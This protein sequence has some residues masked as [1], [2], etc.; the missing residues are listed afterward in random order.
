M[1]S[2]PKEKSMPEE[3][4][5]SPPPC[6]RRRTWAKKRT[7]FT[8]VTYERL[9]ARQKEQFNFQKIAAT[10][11]DYGFSCIK[12]A[13]DWQ[14]ADFLA[15]HIDGTTTLRVQLKS[16]VSIQKKYLGKNIWI[17]FPHKGEW[18]LIEHDR[19]VSKAEKATNWL[20]TPS[21][22]KEGFSS[23]SINAELLDSLTENKLGPVYGVAS[24]RSGKLVPEAKGTPEVHEKLEG[25]NRVQ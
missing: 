10:L 20:N 14:G 17:A 15:Y 5:S 1:H 9:N 21:W 8:K 6:L 13:D 4:E 3:F 18:Y 19:L 2:L 24:T 23:G 25:A 7:Q 16:R 11:A 12:L 22:K